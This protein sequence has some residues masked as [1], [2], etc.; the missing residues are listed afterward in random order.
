MKKEVLSAGNIN[1]QSKVFTRILVGQAPIDPRP[2]RAVKDRGKVEIH[3]EAFGPGG[4]W[5]EAVH[6]ILEKVLARRV[7]SLHETTQPLIMD[8][9]VEVAAIAK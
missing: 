3:V 1:E 9:R 7:D 6:A 8:T 5:A 4:P 2:E